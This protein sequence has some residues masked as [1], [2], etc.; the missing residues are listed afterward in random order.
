MTLNE[1]LLRICDVCL[2]QR[3]WGEPV[4]SPSP[5]PT[6]SA[7]RRIAL[8]RRKDEDGACDCKKLL[9]ANKNQNARCQRQDSHYNRRDSNVNERHESGENQVDSE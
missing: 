4:A 1:N 9:F 3:G 2:R 7:T 5:S 8:V 6:V